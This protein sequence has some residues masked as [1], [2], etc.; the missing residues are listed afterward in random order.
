LALRCSLVRAW[1]SHYGYSVDRPCYIAPVETGIADEGTR[2]GAG[3]DCERGLG[4]TVDHRHVVD[5]AEHR[6]AANSANRKKDERTVSPCVPSPPEALGFEVSERRAALTASTTPTRIRA[7]AV[8]FIAES[9]SEQVQV[10][11]AALSPTMRSTH[12]SMSNSS[13]LAIAVVWFSIDCYPLEH[14]RDRHLARIGTAPA[15][16]G[17]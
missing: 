12:G 2:R 11:T 15:A 14:S 16:R 5:S 7:Q 13:E 4:H 8:G 17:H 6:A 9:A 3:G 1:N 10:R